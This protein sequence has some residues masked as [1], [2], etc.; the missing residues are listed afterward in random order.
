[1]T[2]IELLHRINKHYDAG[3]AR[4]VLRL[5]L[6]KRFGLSW[7]EV[8]CG[9]VETLS[10]EQQSDLESL[11]RLLEEGVPVQYVL[12][13]VDFLGRSFYVGEGVLIPR[14]ET[15][16]L[17]QQ[18][19]EE[20][21]D[22]EGV[23]LLDIGTGS[24]CIAISLALENEDWQVE[25][26][27][28]SDDALKIAKHNTAKHSVMNVKLRK[29]DILHH[30]N[31]SNEKFTAIVSNPPYICNKERAQME[32]HVLDYEPELA[33]FVPDED[34]LLFYRA[35]T[36]FAKTSLIEGGH[37][38][39]EIN[40]EYGHEVAMLMKDNGFTN[41]NIQKDQFGN[42]RIVKGRLL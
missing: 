32:S 3:E 34:P 25:G 24:G 8:L 18:V 5:L 31:T 17:V 23:R 42:D 21:K 19:I 40:R 11:T 22:Y 28:I 27:D 36:A 15:E 10:Y 6:E 35:I 41:V 4:A 39:F 37:L 2:Y 20:A 13:E 38:L 7:T 30:T 26:W 29:I 1:M 9:A 33:L 12:G 16:L 14:P